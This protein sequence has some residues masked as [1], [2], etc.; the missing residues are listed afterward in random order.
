MTKR[1]RDKHESTGSPYPAWQRPIVAELVDMGMQARTMFDDVLVALVQDDVDAAEA[2]VRADDAVDA[3]RVK[4]QVRVVA[5]LAKGGLDAADIHGAFA[6]S[7]TAGHL[8]RLA[9]YAVEIATRVARVTD[10]PMDRLLHEDFLRM[11]ELLDGMWDIA[12]EALVKRDYKSARVLV[13]S[14][15]LVEQLSA[16][17]TKRLLDVGADSRLREWGLVMMLVARGLERA[18]DHLIDVGEQVAYLKTGRP[19]QFRD[20]SQVALVDWPD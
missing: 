11:G 8:E 16:L 17:S 9:D 1:K 18:G 6:L 5:A 2:V 7:S 20:A 12:L 4:V 15:L 14:Q 3:A 10:L 13:D 19:Q